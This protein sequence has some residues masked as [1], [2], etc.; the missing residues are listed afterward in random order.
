MICLSSS[1]FPIF[2]IDDTSAGIDI[3][4]H[5]RENKLGNC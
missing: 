1:Q 4:R 3:R 2:D 5:N